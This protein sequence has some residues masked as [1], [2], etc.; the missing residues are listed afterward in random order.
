MPGTVRATVESLL[1]RPRSG[2]LGINILQV[3]SDFGWATGVR[4]TAGI[5]YPRWKGS[6]QADYM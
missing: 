3:I 6:G 4:D 5:D 1:R 2:H